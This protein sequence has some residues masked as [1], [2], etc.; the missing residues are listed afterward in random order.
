MSPCAVER[1]GDELAQNRR[2]KSQNLGREWCSV[3][4]LEVTEKDAFLELK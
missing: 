3:W 1:E 4:G 2:A